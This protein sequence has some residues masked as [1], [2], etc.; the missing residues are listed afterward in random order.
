MAAQTKVMGPASCRETINDHFN[1]WN[2]KKVIG[3]GACGERSHSSHK[4][5]LVDSHLGPTLLR[6]LKNAVLGRGEHVTNFLEFTESLPP[7]RVLEWTEMVEKWDRNNNETNPFVI[8][9]PGK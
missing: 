2:H 8:V 5:N 3:F 7:D 1:D 4:V 6:R 9:T